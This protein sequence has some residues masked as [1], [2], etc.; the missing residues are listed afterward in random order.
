MPEIYRWYFKF[1]ICNFE[2]NFEECKTLRN[3]REIDKIYI[4]VT[5]D[6]TSEIKKN[7]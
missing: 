7:F 5:E 6:R 2:L 4:I 1:P 3:I